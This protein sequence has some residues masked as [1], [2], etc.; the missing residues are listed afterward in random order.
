MRDT[1]KRLY[2]IFALIAAL[3]PN[4]VSNATYG[5][6]IL[7]DNSMS[8]GSLSW[9]F[10]DNATCTN[11]YPSV[12]GSTPNAITTS[13]N[14]ID[15]QH[16]ILSSS[17]NASVYTFTVTVTSNNTYDGT[18]Q[19]KMFDT[20]G[21]E[22][23]TGLVSIAAGTSRLVVLRFYPKNLSSPLMLSLSGSSSSPINGCNGPIFS[24]VSL[25]ESAPP[26]RLS[27]TWM[28][29][30]VISDVSATSFSLSTYSQALQSCAIG[31][32]YLIY[33]TNPEGILF[34]HRTVK[35]TPTQASANNKFT[36]TDLMPRT[37]YYVHQVAY[38]D[39][40]N[41]L[42]SEPPGAYRNR[43][44]L[45]PPTL[46]TPGAPIL[47][48]NSDNSIN[49][50]LA[51]A[52]PGSNDYLFTLY[53][54]DSKTIAHSQLVSTGVVGGAVPIAGLR[55]GMTY[56]G[57]LVAKSN[58][59]TNESSARGPL[60]SITIPPDPALPFSDN[61]CDLNPS[62]LGALTQIQATSGFCIARIETNTSITIPAGVSHMDVLVVGGGGGGG[63]W[64]G[65]GGGG[66]G[67]T[68]S[69][70]A[71]VS[72]TIAVT[73]GS[74]GVGGKYT[75]VSGAVAGTPGGASSFGNVTALGGGYG[76]T[77]SVYAQGAQGT[78]TS[79]ANG[80]GGSGATQYVGGLGAIRNGG[81]GILSGAAPHPAGGGAGAGQ[82]GGS[83]LMG[84]VNNT[85]DRYCESLGG[86]GGNGLRDINGI[87]GSTSN[88]FGGGGGGG[89]HG[90]Y[91]DNTYLD[92]CAGLPGAGGLGG[93]AL[94]LNPESN[95]YGPQT[96]FSGRPLTGG[97]GGGVGH[98]SANASYGGTGG[99]G[100]VYIRW[101]KPTNG[102]QSISLSLATLSPSF[103]SQVTLNAN[104]IGADARVTFYQNGKRIPGC[105]GVASI[106]FVATC[107][108]KVKIRNSVQLTAVVTTQDGRR[109]TT[110]IPT[111][112][113]VGRRT[114]LR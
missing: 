35:I 85:G 28:T 1:M 102:V 26:P 32:A 21:N 87:S 15:N 58:G 2:I 61:Q 107:Q 68:T 101:S 41:C 64:V 88:Y 75:G 66:G 89:I 70:N 37:L 113:Q 6:N 3:I 65:G 17:L 96:G 82:N 47:T 60:A 57:S 42:D 108:W 27:N 110:L 18:Y 72:G 98:T 31:Y 33:L 106:S 80:G 8:S 94:G 77:W 12:G 9:G 81:N 84:N 53:E 63:A 23:T 99:S 30:M 51:S 44:T 112:V 52:V 92:Y 114:T 73:V 69:L 38:G 40:V 36:I 25:V 54:S 4:E 39:L 74:G 10:S 43:Q 91:F 109:I 100:V 71:A 24:D 29:S 105:I 56:F 76:A 78:N 11:G 50:S 62:R 45:G 49:V 22:T 13:R 46:A 34:L 20:L 90:Y 14:A 93:G 5:V 16:N 79:I 103:Q 55:Y 104:L 86:N 67:V 59:S 48:N 95:P 7:P 97:G 111:T 83:A 19:V